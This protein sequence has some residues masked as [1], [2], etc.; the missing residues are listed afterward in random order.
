MAKLFKMANIT[1]IQRATTMRSLREVFV[2]LDPNTSLK[3]NCFTFEFFD[4]LYR[5][6]QW[7]RS[8]LL[9]GLTDGIGKLIV[10]LVKILRILS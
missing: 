1:H 10:Q 9:V 6:P 3:L 4:P 7:P 8:I 5:K 2:W